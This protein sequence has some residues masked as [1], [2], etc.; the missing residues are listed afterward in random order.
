MCYARNGD[1]E[2]AL[3]ALGNAGTAQPLDPLYR[4]NLAAVL[5]DLQRYDEALRHLAAVHPPSV[6]HSILAFC[7]PN[8]TRR[9]VHNRSFGGDSV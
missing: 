9:P 8:A 2:S 7:S 4:N 5:V 3:T 1:P 6:T